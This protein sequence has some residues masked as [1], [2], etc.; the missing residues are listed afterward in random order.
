[1]TETTKNSA[2]SA[3]VPEASEQVICLPGHLFFVE[4]VELPPALEE[5][6]ISDFAELTVESLAPFPIEQLNWGFLHQLDASS[7]L[8]YAAHRDRLKSQKIEKLEDYTWAVPDFA[9][10]AGAHFPEN[11]EVTLIADRNTTLLHFDAGSEIPSFVASAPN[12]N[13]SPSATIKA[14]RSESATSAAYR[15]KLCVQLIASSLNDRDLPTF[16]FSEEGTNGGEAYGH[17]QTLS[18]SETAL[19]N[20]DVRTLDFKNTERSARRT[21][22]LLTKVTAWVA[23]FAVLLLGLELL[24][25]AANAWLT[26]QTDQI[27]AQ[28]PTVAKIQDRQA[29]MSKLDQVALNELRP[30]AILEALNTSRPAGIYFTSTETG[31]ENRIKIEGIASTINDLNN[32]TA[33]LGK[34]GVFALV[35]PPESLTRRGITTFKVTLDYTHTEPKSESPAPLST[36]TVNKIPKPEA[37]S[38]TPRRAPITKPQATETNEA[39]QDL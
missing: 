20:A 39:S 16:E 33:I 17:W 37:A 28:A 15:R 9:T 25:F 30:I 1:V 29:L 23:I 3:E 4:S 21:S 5:S 31:G 18:P 13:Q 22:R 32:Y 2:P 10:L 7:I 12:K 36:T 34:S 14:L 11:T 35:E 8:V 27:S 38:E 26:T 19:W 6:E 24:M